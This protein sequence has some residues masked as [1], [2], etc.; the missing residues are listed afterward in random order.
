MLIFK[1]YV[2][3]TFPLIFWIS[4]SNIALRTGTLYEAK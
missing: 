3:R 4:I 2:E 1:D